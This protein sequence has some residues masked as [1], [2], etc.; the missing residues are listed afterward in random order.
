M[1]EKYFNVQLI[2]NDVR[3]PLFHS[4]PEITLDALS[5][6]LLKV[7]ISKDVHCCYT[8]KVGKVGDMEVSDIY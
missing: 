6:I 3:Q 7:L 8:C 2:N 4:I 5:M 1:K